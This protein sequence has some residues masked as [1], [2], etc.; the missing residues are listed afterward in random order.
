MTK[1]IGAAMTF[2][3]IAER[4]VRDGPDGVLFA[5]EFNGVR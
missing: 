2:A 4:V 1:Q 5:P 3:E